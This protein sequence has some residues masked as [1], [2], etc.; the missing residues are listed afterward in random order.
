M[1]YVIL[2]LISALSISAIAIYYS[3]AGL[4]AIFSAAAIPIIVMGS[5]LEISKLVTAVWL[6]KFWHQAKWWLKTYLCIAVF[7]LMFITSMG[8]F[9]FLSKAHIEQ[10]AAS[11]EN[12]AQLERID[13]ELIRY[14]S[15]IEKNQNK[16]KNYEIQGV[17]GQSNLQ[18]QIDKEQSRIDSAYSRIQPLVDEQNVIIRNVTKFYQ[19]ELDKVDNDLKILKSY[20][21]A[22]EIAKAQGIV[23]TKADGKYGPATAQAFLTYQ[24]D[25]T[26][27]RDKWLQKIEDSVNSNEVI[28]AKQE[29]SRLRSYAEKQVTESN[30]VIISLQERLQTAN[31]NNIS[32]LI[33]DSE[34]IIK[35]ANKEIESLLSNKYQIQ[36][37]YRKLE[38]EVGPIKYI[39][40]FVYGDADRDLL[41]DAVRW[42]I[43]TIIFVFDPLAVLLLIASQYT[44]GYIG[45][46]DINLLPNKKHEHKPTEE[47]TTQIQ[48]D[49]PAVIEEEKIPEPEPVSNNIFANIKVKPL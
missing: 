1:L 9:G 11:I 46:K 7:V 36:S 41:E 5:V 26:A 3:V 45:K 20:I 35:S 47:K 38:A 10:T 12:V 31:N 4:V 24:Q 49:T 13:K 2:T 39:A 22:G 27:E 25:K 14:E 17:G 42:V 37:E 34:D 32:L 48:Q 43:I 28:A 40:E 15:V 29:I 8:I 16:I 23:G 6:H 44:L 21:D 30:N 18:A 19:S 33:K